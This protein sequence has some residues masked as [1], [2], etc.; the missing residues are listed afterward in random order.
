MNYG[1]NVPSYVYVH[2][3]IDIIL[4]LILDITDNGVCLYEIDISGSQYL[5]LWIQYV[6]FSLPNVQCI[7]CENLSNLQRRILLDKQFRETDF[8]IPTS[9][10]VSVNIKSVDKEQ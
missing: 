6:C 9:S 1:T 7:M 8:S 5:L 4:I 3:Y 10:I 2:P